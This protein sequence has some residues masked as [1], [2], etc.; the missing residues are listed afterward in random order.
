VFF[1][2]AGFSCSAGMPTMAQFG[3]ASEFDFDG[4]S[5]DHNKVKL[6]REM[7]LKAGVWFRR[8]QKYCGDN[9][10]RIDHNNM[11]DVY[12]VA[13][14]LVVA[15]VA[16]I[17]L[18]GDEIFLK[19][20]LIQIKLWL[21]KVFQQFPPANRD[22]VGQVD[23]NPYRDFISYFKD[24]AISPR[25]AVITTNYDL[26][27]EHYAW[28]GGVSCSYPFCKSEACEAQIGE[29]TNSKYVNIEDGCGNDLMIYKLH[30][31]INYFSKE[32]MDLK[33]FNGVTPAH[34][35]V[36]ESIWGVDAPSIF[37]LDAIFEIKN[38]Y[39]DYA[40]AIVA[41]TY[42]K[43]HSCSWV[44]QIWQGAIKCLGDA[45]VIVFIGYGMP[46]TDG[47]IKAMFQAA[48]S[49]KGKASPKIYVLNRDQYGRVA[50][51]Y[52][53][54]FYKNLEFHKGTFVEK[55][56]GLSSQILHDIKR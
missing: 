24:N 43:A 31:S 8:F 32:E 36:G 11:E 27:L 25:T 21:W 15:G 18:E 9:F 4:I 14:A 23:E 56:P 44:Q 10:V 3:S 6:S 2:G 33:I 37:L 26:I 30:G 22:R 35:K 1:L 55:W 7:L 46:Q 41:P 16:S 17:R 54:L 12:C 50:E 19:D 49:G 52:S 13:E 51:R 53:D 39:P 42:A 20:L 34:K 29:V 5:K 47:F 48:F 40:P 45:K 38:K 28:L